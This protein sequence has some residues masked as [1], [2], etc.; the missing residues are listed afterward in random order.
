MKA[1]HLLIILIALIL[2]AGQIYRQATSL[3]RQFL[4]DRDEVVRIQAAPYGEVGTE[5]LVIQGEE[6]AEAIIRAYNQGT[7]YRESL[8][9]RR[10]RLEVSIELENGETFRIRDYSPQVFWVTVERQGASHEFRISS[11]PLGREFNR[12]AEKF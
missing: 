5:P 1:W 2:L 12:L 9:G 6:E 3:P 10:P 8:W 11:R 7:N 4:I